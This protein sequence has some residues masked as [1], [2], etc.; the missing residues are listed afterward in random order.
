MIPD[1]PQH[2]LSQA[3]GARVVGS[4]GLQSVRIAEMHCFTT[5]LDDSQLIIGNAVGKNSRPAGAL[6]EMHVLQWSS[7]GFPL[8]PRPDPYR[9]HLVYKGLVL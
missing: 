7:D 6:Q 4:G 3:E 5:F 1:R 8:M 9:L 2:F